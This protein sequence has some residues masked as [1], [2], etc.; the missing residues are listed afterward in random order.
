MI[1]ELLIIFI[2]ITILMLMF[3]MILIEEYLDLA[4]IAVMVG[5]FFAVITSYGFINVEYYT[6]GFNVTS[7]NIENHVF[8]I[9]GYN[10]PYP[11]VFLMIVFF[12]VALFFKIAFKIWKKSLE[13]AEIDSYKKRR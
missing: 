8:Q 2:I 4:I 12:F 1:L 7:G 10:E 13:G 9:T 6:S 5:I 11:I 3:A